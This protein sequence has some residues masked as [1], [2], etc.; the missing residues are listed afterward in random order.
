MEVLGK[1]PDGDDA[2]YAGLDL[3]PGTAQA[4]IAD[5]SAAPVAA[6]RCGDTAR[7]IRP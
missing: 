6:V 7:A 1:G 3:L 2:E 5:H 4:M